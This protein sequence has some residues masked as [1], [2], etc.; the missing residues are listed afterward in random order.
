MKNFEFLERKRGAKEAAAADATV[1][2]SRNSR[3][4]Q[5][6]SRKIQSPSRIQD[7]LSQSASESKASH[8]LGS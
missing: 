6:R 2:S 4:R 3:K 1:L 8:R 7:E 5:S